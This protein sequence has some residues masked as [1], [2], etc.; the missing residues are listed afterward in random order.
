MKTVKYCA[1]GHF[2]E[3]NL[4]PEKFAETKLGMA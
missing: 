4:V 2:A 3:T 1:D